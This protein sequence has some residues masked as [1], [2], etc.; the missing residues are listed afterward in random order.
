MKKGLILFIL[1]LS[2][3][4]PNSISNDLILK[5]GVGSSDFGVA[6]VGIAAAILMRDNKKK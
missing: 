5:S 2:F 3:L 6:L 4:L 1:C